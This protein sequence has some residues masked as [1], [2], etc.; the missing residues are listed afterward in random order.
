MRYKDVNFI[1]YYPAIWVAHK[2]KWLPYELIPIYFIAQD[3]NPM[4]AQ[5]AHFHLTNQIKVK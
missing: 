2:L 3:S 1:V 4:L 5:S